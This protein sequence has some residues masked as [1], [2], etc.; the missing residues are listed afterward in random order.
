MDVEM[1]NVLG[2]RVL[3]THINGHGEIDISSLAAGHYY[4]N[5]ASAGKTTRTRIAVAR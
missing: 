5:I 1:I 2:D 4:V 3:K